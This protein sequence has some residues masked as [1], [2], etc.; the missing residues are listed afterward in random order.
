M[1]KR[2]AS[3]A[4]TI[5]TQQRHNSGNVVQG[6][7]YSSTHQH[8]RGEQPPLQFSSI[9]VSHAQDALHD[10]FVQ[11]DVFPSPKARATIALSNPP[12]CSLTHCTGLR[13]A[14][15]LGLRTASRS[16]SPLSCRRQVRGLRCQRGDFWSTGSRPSAPLCP[17]DAQQRGWAPARRRNAVMALFAYTQTGPLTTIS[18]LSIQR[19]LHQATH[20]EE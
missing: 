15:A 16:S 19:R 12:L 7:A 3:L 4:G 20:C 5:S 1:R 10:R 18:I 17:T 8:N 9:V 2:A 13:K 11:P 14:C 6:A